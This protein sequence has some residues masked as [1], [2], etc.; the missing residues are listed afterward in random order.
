MAA[1]GFAPDVKVWTVKGGKGF[2]KVVRG[3]ECSGHT[4]GIFHMSWRSDS[5]HLATISKD[6][7]WKVFNLQDM[8][9]Y[10]NMVNITIMDARKHKP[11]SFEET[12]FTLI[13][14]DKVSF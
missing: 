3:F 2:D 6:Q 10:H 9:E 14:L 1:C 11:G 7:T 12:G 5:S 4:S 8:A 13:T